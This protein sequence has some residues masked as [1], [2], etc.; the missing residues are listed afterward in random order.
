MS[1]QYHKNYTFEETDTDDFDGLAWTQR[2]EVD[3]FG[4]DGPDPVTFIETWE[5]TDD[6]HT[7]AVVE[8]NPKRLRELRDFLVGLDLD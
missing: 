5:Y 8:L 7:N 4:A 3:V 1:Q 2:L 6:V